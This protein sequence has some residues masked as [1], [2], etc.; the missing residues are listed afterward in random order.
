MKKFIRKRSYEML[1]SSLQTH[2]THCPKFW[3]ERTVCVFA[4]S[5]C[6]Y[7]GALPHSCL[8]RE[9]FTVLHCVALAST[10]WITQCGSHSVVLFFLFV[11]RH[12][13]RSIRLYTARFQCL[14]NEPAN[15]TRTLNACVIL[16]QQ[17]SNTLCFS[18]SSKTS[19][20]NCSF[21]A[22]LF[23]GGKNRNGKTPASLPQIESGH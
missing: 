23:N 14:S 12:S 22:A 10:V 4:C 16:G 11:N 3:T 15:N 8:I 17:I 6:T 5:L 20:K 2:T 21:F 7:T 13:V 19:S 18:K 1:C 9:Y